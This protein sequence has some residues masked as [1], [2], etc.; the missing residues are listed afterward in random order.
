MSKYPLQGPPGGPKTKGMVFIA[1]NNKDE[2]IVSDPG[3]STVTFYKYEGTPLYSFNPQ[4]AVDGLGFVPAGIAVD[5][6]NQIVLADCLNRV[7]N[8]YS[9]RGVLL[10]HHAGPT[11]NVG[12][13][14]TVALGMEG[15]L[16][17]AEC[18]TNG[19]H[20]VKIFRYNDCACHR[21]RPG[22]SMRHTPVPT[23]LE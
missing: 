13:V 15:H 23:D 19:P 12:A 8:V 20:C 5:F 22:S 3:T 9:E 2:V 16:V 11:D 17:A 7:I 10:H 1:L 4:A 14:Q 6:L 21:D 18:A